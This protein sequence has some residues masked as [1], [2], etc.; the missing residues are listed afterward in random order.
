[1]HKKG[2][3]IHIQ[4]RTLLET[5]PAQLQVLTLCEKHEKWASK[6]ILLSVQVYKYCTIF[7]V[8]DHF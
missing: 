3:I 4:E 5:R 6:A 7:A 8:L 1:V 2:E